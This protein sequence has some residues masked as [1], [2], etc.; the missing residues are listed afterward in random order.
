MIQK[1]TEDFL[2]KKNVKI[3]KRAHAFKGYACSYNV[4][5]LNSFNPELQLTD[6]E[7]AI[8][9]NLVELLS[10]YKGF[11]FV[12][13]LVLVFKKMKV[14]IKQSK[15]IFYSSLKADHQS[16]DYYPARI[17]K[18]NKNFAK[19]LDFKDIKFPVKIRDI[20]K[21]EKKIPSALVFLDMKIKKNTQSM[22]Q[23]NVAKKKL[24]NY[25]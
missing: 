18:A 2:N 4:E 17:T 15:T 24:L 12:I 14:K 3:T 7:S 25:Y 10:E 21:I 23:N 5:V 13:T 11:K 8:K 6:T 1:K 20:H 9:C 22:Y 16:A 19:R